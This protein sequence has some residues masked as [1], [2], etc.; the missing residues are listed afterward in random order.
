MP[1]YGVRGSVA[2]ELVADVDEMLDG[3][4]VDII[5]RGEVEDDGFEGGLFGFDGDGFAAARARVVPRAV[6]N[7][8]L[9]EITGKRG[10][11]AYAEFGI[12]G[13]VGAAGFFEDG[14]DHVVEVVGGVGVVETFREAVD[15][16]TWVW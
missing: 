15:E 5:D 3:C 16:D 1:V 6:L 7:Y 9:V 11:R 14:G 10:K 13:G 12:E 4:D 8:V 2:V